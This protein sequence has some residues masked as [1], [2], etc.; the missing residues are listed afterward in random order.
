MRIIT[1]HQPGSL[2]DVLSIFK[3]NE[4][5]LTKIQ[6]MPLIGRPYE[7]AFNIDITWKIYDVYQ[8]ALEE[9]KEITEEIKIHGEY[10]KGKI[11]KI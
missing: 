11:P 4:I 10:E 5:N 9:L 8:T 3:A 7:Y 6:S 2:A 1:K